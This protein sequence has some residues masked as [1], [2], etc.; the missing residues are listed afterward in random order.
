MHYF[1]CLFVVVVVVVVVVS[2]KLK[3]LLR[4]KTCLEKRRRKQIQMKEVMKI[5]Q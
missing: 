4:M 1:V 5:S 3:G 2:R